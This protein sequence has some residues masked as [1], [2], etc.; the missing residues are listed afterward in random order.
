MHVSNKIWNVKEWKENLFL[1]SVPS[2]SLVAV[3]AAS[4]LWILLAYGKHLLLSGSPLSMLFCILH[5]FF[6]L[7]IDS[8]KYK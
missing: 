4:F 8:Y 1:N 2:S 6:V 7:D 3:I 5:F